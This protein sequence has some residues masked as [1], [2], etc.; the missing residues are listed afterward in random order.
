[1]DPSTLS[2]FRDHWNGLRILNLI[3]ESG[4]KLLITWPIGVGKSRNIDDL[5]EAALQ[6]GRYDLVVVLLP[7]RKTLN[8]RR[9][10]VHPPVSVCV[11]NLRPRP[12]ESCGE[13]VNKQWKIY[14]S[15]GMA[16]LGRKRICRHCFHYNKCF[17][18]SQYGKKLQGAQVIFAT[19]SH[20]ERDPTF[21]DQI[22]MWTG[23]KKVLVILDEVNFIAKSLRR[24]I[25]RGVLQRFLNALERIDEVYQK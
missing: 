21:I 6:S 8:E 2:I 3:A 1:L 18:P 22:R 4:G 12:K 9:W 24:E 13:D 10:V 7:T 23:A 16:L 19:Q 14:E 25:K 11:V 15:H 5:V 17:W 20:L